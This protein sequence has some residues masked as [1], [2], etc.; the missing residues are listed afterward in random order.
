MS[1]VFD[2]PRDLVFK[3]YTDPKLIPQWWGPEKYLTVVE[4]M[5]FRAG[6]EWRFVQ[7]DSTDGSVFAFRGVF[8]EIKEPEYITWTFEFEPMP[9][10]IS[11]ETVYFEEV[12]EGKTKITTVSS[13]K[14]IEDLEGMAQ[15][16]MEEGANEGWDR[17]EKILE[18]AK[19]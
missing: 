17:F 14:T 7:T 13:Y 18:K 8:K 6:G 11:T 3:I 15:S 9:G 16:G 19:N 10:H 12:E 4:K 1:R 5:D 2:A